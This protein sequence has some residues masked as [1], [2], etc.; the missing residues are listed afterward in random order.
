MAGAR[1]AE[2]PG[3]ICIEI[4]DLPKGLHRRSHEWL[5]GFVRPRFLGFGANMP[6]MQKL[7]GRAEFVKGFADG[8][9][10]VG[11]LCTAFVISAARMI[12][13]RRELVA[14]EEAPRRSTVGDVVH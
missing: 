2:R 6:A 14:S 13:L 7:E 1:R 8:S 10:S 9:E 5:Q 3:R 11:V 4:R 12:T